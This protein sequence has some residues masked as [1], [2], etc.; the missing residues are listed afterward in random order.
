[1]DT[2][3]REYELGFKKSWI[4]YAEVIF[5]IRHV[6]YESFWIS[7]ES[8]SSNT[9][10]SD[11]VL[12]SSHFYHYFIALVNNILSLV[13]A[14]FGDQRYH[15]HRNQFYYD[16]HYCC[17]YQTTTILFIKAMIIICYRSNYKSAF[18][19]FG[20]WERL[21]SIEWAKKETNK[22]MQCCCKK[23]IDGWHYNQYLFLPF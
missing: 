4:L 11:T 14:I 2:C 6:S 9:S 22:Y 19:R 10:V 13:I 21:S 5:D 18:W 8:I 12:S 23:G 20:K 17:R 3:L 1:M 15:N 16:H 7:E